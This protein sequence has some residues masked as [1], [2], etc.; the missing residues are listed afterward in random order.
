MS[1]L[2]V[3]YYSAVHLENKFGIK[4]PFTHLTTL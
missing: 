2:L 4:R 3:L 1:T